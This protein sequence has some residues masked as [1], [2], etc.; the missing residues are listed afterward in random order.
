M[1]GACALITLGLK[2]WPGALDAQCWI[3]NAAKKYLEDRQ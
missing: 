2:V 3:V 1:G